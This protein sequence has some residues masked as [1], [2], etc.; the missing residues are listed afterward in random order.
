M[1]AEAA[2]PWLR[3]LWRRV[4]VIAFCVGWIGVEAVWLEPGGMWVWLAVAITAWGV[5]DFF[6]SGKYRAVA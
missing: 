4:A 3:P 6:L 2:H 5:W 1:A